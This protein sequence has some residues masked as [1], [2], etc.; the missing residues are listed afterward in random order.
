MP[1]TCRALLTAQQ[2]SRQKGRQWHGEWLNPV[3]A[4]AFTAAILYS[5]HARIR[6]KIYFLIA[7]FFSS[8]PKS[9]YRSSAQ[10]AGTCNGCV[11]QV[12]GRCLCTHHTAGDHCER[13]APLYNDHPWRPA[14]SSS[15]E[16]NPC[17][18]KWQQTGL[19][20]IHPGKNEKGIKL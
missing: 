6:C 5:K 8:H 16:S 7:W 15:G 9:G 19:H 3:S 14:N 11:F 12:P 2:Q 17:R 10:T 1:W 4:G 18:S 13:C 20:H